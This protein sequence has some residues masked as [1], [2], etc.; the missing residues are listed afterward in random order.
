MVITADVI[1]KNLQQYS[2]S[3]YDKSSDENT[4]RKN[5]P[6]HNKGYI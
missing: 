2:T 1:K 4:N 3:S 5:V 6:Q